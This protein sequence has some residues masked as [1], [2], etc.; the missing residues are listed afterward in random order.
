MAQVVILA[1]QR[2]INSARHPTHCSEAE[3]VVEVMAAE[4]VAVADA[5]KEIHASTD[6][7]VAAA[8]AAMVAS[9]ELVWACA[10]LVD[11]ADAAGVAV[12]KSSSMGTENHASVRYE[13][14]PSCFAIH[15]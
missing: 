11:A 1:V 7:E 5:D 14:W 10:V 9:M 4:A 15:S 12:L 13:D 8:S 3:A 6:L 2:V